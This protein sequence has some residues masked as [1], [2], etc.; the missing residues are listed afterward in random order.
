MRTHSRSHARSHNKL[1]M[2]HRQS[3]EESDAMNSN[4]KSAIT[5]YSFKATSGSKTKAIEETTSTPDF[6][7]VVFQSWG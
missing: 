6:A 3:P 1:K 5:Q 2:L 4:I 7:N